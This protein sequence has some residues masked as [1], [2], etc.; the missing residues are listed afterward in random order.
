MGGEWIYFYNIFCSIVPDILITERVE[1][2]AVKE[3]E[4]FRLRCDVLPGAGH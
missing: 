3:G 4:E 2:V 1:R